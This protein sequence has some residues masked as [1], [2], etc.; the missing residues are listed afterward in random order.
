MANGNSNFVP[1]FGDISDP[2]NMLDYKIYLATTYC[3]TLLKNPNC[4]A[5]QV[6]AAIQN[7]GLLHAQLNALLAGTIALNSPTPGDIST[8]TGLVSKVEALT[9]SD[10]DVT[11][12]LALLAQV[13]AATVPLV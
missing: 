4:S 10:A 5:S 13:A 11:A 2:E 9:S 1:G 6:G 8:I 12:G 7:L 3:S